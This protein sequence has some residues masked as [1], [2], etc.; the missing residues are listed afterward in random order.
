MTAINFT[1]PDGAKPRKV[2][3]RTAAP[4][5][6]DL[7]RAIDALHS[8]PPDIGREDWVRVGMAAHAAGIGFDDFDQW[9][10]GAESYDQRAAR[11]TWRSFKDGGGIG[12]GTLFKMAEG[13]G[14]NLKASSASSKTPRA[15][16]PRPPAPAAI[17]RTEKP[18]KKYDPAEVWNRCAPVVGHDYIVG[19][20]AEGVPLDDLRVVPAGDS[21]HIMDTSMAGALVVPC[22]GADGQLASLQFVTTGDTAARLKAAGKK[23]KLNLP[24]HSMNGWHVVGDVVPGGVVYV[25]EGIG[26]AWACWQAT[27]RA[28][29]VAFGWGS[30]K[31]VAAALLELHPDATLVLVP[32]AGKEADAANIA[33]A[34]GVQRV[35]LPEGLPKNFD[36]SDLAARDGLEALELL[37]ANPINPETEAALEVAS[38]DDG[39]AAP[40]F[41]ELALAEQFAARCSGQF[42]WSPGMDWMVNVGSHWVRDDHLKRFN[43]AK[44]V[45]RA[46]ASEAEKEK[47]QLASKLCSAQTTSNLLSLAR[48]ESGIVT[49]VAEWNAW[50]ML[51][52]TTGAVYDLRTGQA[53]PREGHLFTQ[54]AS[55]EPKLMPTPVWSKF[56]ADVFDNDVAMIEFIQRLAGY[57]LT[58]SIKEQKLFF[59]YGEGSNGKSVLLDVLRDIAGTYGHS[60][61]SE[62]LM[63][64]KHDRHPTTLAALQGK[65]LAISSEIEESSHWAEARIKQLTGDKTLTARFMRGD[66]FTFDITHK[67]ILAGNFKPRFKGDDFAMQRRMV[68]VPFTQR[69]EGLRRDDHLRDK[70]V[71]ECPGILAWAI[72]GAAKWCES[73][74]LIPES[75]QTSSKDYMAEQDDLALWIEECCTV[76]DGLKAKSSEL[77][78]SFDQWKRRN[79]ENAGSNKNFSQRLERKFQKMPRSSSGLFFAGLQ[80]RPEFQQNDYQ[81]RSRGF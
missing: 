55:V 79:G 67:H 46:V 62:A 1:L 21:L 73:G 54:V 39:L 64:S 75:V 57:C 76:G 8:I 32:D 69:F 80:L 20:N 7:E 51:L 52:N 48:S 22:R 6:N 29:V 56:L 15:T 30:V 5:M 23:T 10:A 71:A 61:P 77:F 50:P 17:R 70:L 74:L 41:S 72:E 36:V 9:S 25:C 34:L 59:L 58:G 27:G 66:E 63:S 13:Y 24:G 81:N 14:F 28:A 35:E 42:R 33:L 53:V 26:Q 12:A 16:L 37:L 38:D 31:K 43:V 49:P 45:C 19:K 65:R 78:Q 18:V 4:A 11:D 2:K 44:S 68:L 3:A 47:P 60:L 40:G